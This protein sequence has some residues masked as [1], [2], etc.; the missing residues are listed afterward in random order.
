MNH[1]ENE[2]FSHE[3]AVTW[4]FWHGESADIHFIIP[5]GP[6]GGWIPQRAA[7]VKH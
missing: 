5:G 3:C 1:V 7:S 4:W 2:I 6:G